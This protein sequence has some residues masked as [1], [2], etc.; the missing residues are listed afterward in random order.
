MYKINSIKEIFNKIEKEARVIIGLK[1][2][3]GWEHTQRVYRLCMHIG[4]KEKADL[5]VLGFAAVLHDICRKDEDNTGGR[6]CH[7]KKGAQV[8]GRILEKY[9]LDKER[10]SKVLHCIETHRFR[11]NKRHDSLEA[12]VLFDSDKLDSIGAVGIG[13]AFQFAGEVGAKLHNREVSISKTKPYTIEDTAYREYII[14]LIKIKQNIITKEGKRIAR[15][16]HDFMK[17]F[18]KKLDLEVKGIE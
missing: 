18:F 15:K 5:E 4:K 17:K 2:S 10:I 11:G 14:K 8:A 12:K 9:G 6:I 3:H 16:R 13:R 1:G 7:A